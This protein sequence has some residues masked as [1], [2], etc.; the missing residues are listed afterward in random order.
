MD[1]HRLL[2]PRPII[3]ALAI[4]RPEIKGPHPN[5]LLALAQTRTVAAMLH[6]NGPKLLPELATVQATAMRPA[7]T[8]RLTIG[9]NVRLAPTPT[10]VTPRRQTPE[11]LPEQA[12]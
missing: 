12:G 7:T 8:R 4:I 3:R 6:G 1:A 9:D 2:T 11:R 5:A 10:P